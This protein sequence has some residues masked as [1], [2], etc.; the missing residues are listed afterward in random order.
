MT[1]TSFAKTSALGP[2]NKKINSPEVTDHRPRVAAE[3]RERMRSRLLRSALRL[4]AEKGPGS[5]SIEDVI[6]AAQVSRGTFYKYF[7]SPDALVREL[8][9]EIA[10]ELIRI[11]EPMVRSHD[12]PAELVARGIRLGSRVAIHYP[13]FAGF[14]LRLGWPGEQGPNM[15]E[16]VR[17]DIE[18][19]FRRGRFLRMPMAL[20]LNIVAGAVLGAIHGMMGSECKEDFSGQAAAVALRA[21]GVDAAAADAIANTPLDIDETQFVGLLAETLINVT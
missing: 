17:R 19:G 5:T 15:L 7:P 10:N 14:L 9:T 18:E 11:V 20:A 16:F 6:L 4:V 13:A 12:D 8:A 1:N 21:L 2:S 3:R